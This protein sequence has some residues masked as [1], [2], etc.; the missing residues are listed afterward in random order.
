ME[1]VLVLPIILMLLLGLLEFSLLF[2]ARGDVVDASRL[3]ARHATLA[4]A[5][6]Q[7]IQD[8]ALSA[9]PPKLRRSAEVVVDPGVH[10]GDPVYVA[11]RVP[12]SAAAPDLLWPAGFSLQ[13]NHLL[14]ETRMT[15]E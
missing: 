14:A 8:A 15:K 2:F 1:L 12:M 6:E 10:S 4:G 3:A 13:G 9:L 11:V 5:T 7:D